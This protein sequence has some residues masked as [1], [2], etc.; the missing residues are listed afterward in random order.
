MITDQYTAG[1]SVSQLS[2]LAKLSYWLTLSI[3]DITTSFWHY[4]T[5]CWFL[6]NQTMGSYH[7]FEYNEVKSVHLLIIL[8]K[9]YLRSRI[10]ERVNLLHMLGWQ[11]SSI[12]GGNL[13]MKT[14]NRTGLLVNGHAIYLTIAFPTIAENFT[15]WKLP[16]YMSACVI[17]AIF[18]T[19]VRYKVRM[20]FIEFSLNVC[21]KT[22]YSYLFI[23][24]ILLLE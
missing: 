8:N 1:G 16:K 21:Y 19:E 6:S 20:Y 12:L 13:L 15:P 18:H 2:Q 9:D 7:F 14:P 17:L 11:P 23:F 5:W 24:S 10:K 3:K 4:N 22:G